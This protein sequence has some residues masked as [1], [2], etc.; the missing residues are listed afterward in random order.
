ME[1]IGRCPLNNGALCVQKTRYSATY[2]LLSKH[3]M[4]IA[5]AM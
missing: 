3:L 5:P 1:R 2:D 4:F